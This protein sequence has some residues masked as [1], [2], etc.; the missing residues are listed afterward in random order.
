[1]MLRVHEVEPDFALE[2]LGLLVPVPAPGA[3]QDF[4][5]PLV[6]V[7]AD[8]AVMNYDQTPAAPEELLETVALLADDLH[9]VRG[10]DHQH[11]GVLEFVPSRKIHRAVRFGAALVEQILPFPEKAR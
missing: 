3:A 11:I 5:G 6:L 10:V 4:F 8:H 7:A 1:G 2:P 9:A